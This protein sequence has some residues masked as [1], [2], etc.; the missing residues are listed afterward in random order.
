MLDCSLSP[1][2]VM[3]EVQGPVKLQLATVDKAH[4]F[5]TALDRDK[6]MQHTLF[7]WQVVLTNS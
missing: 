5:G 1:R 6:P 7:L 4:R 2:R 3:P